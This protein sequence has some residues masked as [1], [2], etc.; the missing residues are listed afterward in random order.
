M[1]ATLNPEDITHVVS[2]H[3][4]K[5]KEGKGRWS[6][7]IECQLVKDFFPKQCN[8]KVLPNC[9]RTINLLK[10]NANAKIGSNSVQIRTRLVQRSLDGIINQS[11]LEKK[12]LIEKIS[13][14]KKK[15]T[16]TSSFC[17][18]NFLPSNWLS[19]DPYP[20]LY[21][22]ACLTGFDLFEGVAIAGI[23]LRLEI[24]L[25]NLL[26]ALHLPYSIVSP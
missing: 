19:Y 11:S 15:G 14:K 3:G 25:R 1:L 24:N 6:V 4:Q 7:L 23:T 12:D 8:H 2:S 17:E 9:Y 13:K 22:A 18:G 16:S 5:R 26:L 20:Q 21:S 10:S